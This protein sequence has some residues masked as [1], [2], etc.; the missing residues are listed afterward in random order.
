VD[1]PHK[2]KWLTG[3][4]SPAAL[5]LL[6]VVLS[7]SP[8]RIIMIGDFVPLFAAIGIFYWA[9]FRPKR[10]PYWFIFIL[11]LVQD[12]LFGMPL[13]ISSLAYLLF[14]YMVGSQRRLFIKEAF[15]AVWAGFS[16]FASL[17]FIFIWV[18]MSLY[19]QMVLPFASSILQ[20]IFTALC[21]PLLHLLYTRLYMPAHHTTQEGA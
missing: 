21:Y 13:G 2:S 17:L 12:A 16:G 14:R 11:G 8:K 4:V 3:I 10:M 1:R 7:A 20:W 5:T 9:L 18:V 19:H 15:W 6:L